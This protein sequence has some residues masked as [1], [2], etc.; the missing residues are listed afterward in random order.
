MDDF[1]RFVYLKYAEKLFLVSFVWQITMEFMRPAAVKAVQD[2]LPADR[3][4]QLMSVRRRRLFF[5]KQS[6]KQC[7]ETVLNLHKSGFASC[8]N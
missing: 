6:L 4:Q 5:S 8:V 2:I 3:W 1:A 7:F